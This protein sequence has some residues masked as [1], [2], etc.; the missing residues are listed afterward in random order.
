MPSDNYR[1]IQ[2]RLKRAIF[3][4]ALFN[5]PKTPEIY[6]VASALKAKIRVI[7]YYPCKAL[8]AGLSLRVQV[9]RNA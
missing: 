4:I 6:I 2:I 9:S 5:Y 3:N 7:N 1:L 8:P